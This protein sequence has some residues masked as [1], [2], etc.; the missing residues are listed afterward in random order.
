MQARGHVREGDVALFAS[1]QFTIVGEALLAHFHQQTKLSR[2]E[3]I[4]EVVR[5]VEAI[6]APEPSPSRSRNAN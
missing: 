1:L 4:D 2:D 5:V 6:A 3:V